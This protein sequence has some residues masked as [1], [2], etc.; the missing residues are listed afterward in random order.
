[1]SEGMTRK[2]NKE[3]SGYKINKLIYEKEPFTIYDAQ[4]YFPQR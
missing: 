3:F 4:L 2:E 1:M